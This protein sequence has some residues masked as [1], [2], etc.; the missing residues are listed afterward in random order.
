MMPLGGATGA[1]P[2]E[3]LYSYLSTPTIHLQRF[4]H[5]NSVSDKTPEDVSQHHYSI[6]TKRTGFLLTTI[7]TDEYPI[8]IPTCAVQ[9]KPVFSK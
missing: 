7:F 1:I 4:I 8:N 6:G 2:L 5:I 9:R 3:I